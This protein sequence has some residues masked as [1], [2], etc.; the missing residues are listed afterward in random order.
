MSALGGMAIVAMGFYAA[1]MTGAII[2]VLGMG[3]LKFMTD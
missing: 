3:L 1:G 2:A